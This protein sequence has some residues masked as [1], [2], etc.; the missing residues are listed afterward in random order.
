MTEGGISAYHKVIT[1]WKSSFTNS[2]ILYPNAL[3][4]SIMHNSILSSCKVKIKSNSN[5]INALPIFPPS[6]SCHPVLCQSPLHLLHHH[7]LSVAHDFP[8]PSGL[9]YKGKPYYSSTIK[10]A[11]SVAFK[12]PLLN[13]LPIWNAFPSCFHYPNA[14]NSQTLKAHLFHEASL[15]SHPS[16]LWFHPSLLTYS[17]H[18]LHWPFGTLLPRITV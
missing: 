4:E 2:S 15:S 1:T 7:P 8:L 9:W 13:T 18:Y 16:P 11:C 17:I 12:Y 6:H 3:H 5:E 14:T 10:L